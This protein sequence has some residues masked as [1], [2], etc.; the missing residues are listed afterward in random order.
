MGA[1]DDQVR[2][3]LRP[4]GTPVALGM[5]AIFLATVM[6]SGLQL[7]WLSGADEQRPVRF[8]ALGAAFPLELLA[9]TL[10]F[11]GRDALLG[12]GF[13]I[14]SGVWSVTGLTLL[15][16]RPGGTNDALGMFLV[17]AAIGLALLLVS[18]GGARLLLGLMV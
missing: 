7:E 18:A 4:L 13:G 11:L 6:L 12:T 9:A 15:T 3:T 14:F 8:L 2:V 17:L 10:A 16:G 5:A 1:V